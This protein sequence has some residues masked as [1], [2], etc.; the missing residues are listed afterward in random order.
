MVGNADANNK[1]VV[2]IVQCCSSCL[3]NLS[4]LA[5]G[6]VWRVEKDDEER[7][8]EAIIDGVT[9]KGGEFG[10]QHGTDT[11]GHRQQHAAGIEASWTPQDKAQREKDCDG[12]Q[13]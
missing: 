10:K 9:G 12:T 6:R 11:D 13:T 3:K 5:W 1:K 2:L 8:G 7:G 4:V